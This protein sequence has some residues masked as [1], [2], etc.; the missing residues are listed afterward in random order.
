MNI[1]A[2]LSACCAA[3]VLTTSSIAMS[4]DVRGPQQWNGKVPARD[5]VEI[6]FT[7]AADDTTVITVK[8]DGDTDV[9]CYLKDDNDNVTK[10]DERDTDTCVLVAHPIR[11]ADFKLVLINRGRVFNEVSV[12]TN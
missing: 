11:T 10:M 4:G 2:M 5:G 3:I 6:R 1:R 7:L 8:G 9:D 12:R